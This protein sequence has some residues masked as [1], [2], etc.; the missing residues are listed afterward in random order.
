ML[1]L[2][3]KLSFA[4]RHKHS[5]GALLS[6]QYWL[7]FSACIYCGHASNRATWRGIWEPRGS[8][9]GWPL[10]CQL[11]TFWLFS[12]W[13]LRSPPVCC[14]FMKTTT[15]TGQPSHKHDLSRTWK[16]CIYQFGASCFLKGAFFS[17]QWFGS[18]ELPADLRPHCQDRRLR[19]LTQPLQGMWV[20]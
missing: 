10:T 12:E 1:A 4:E 8:Q 19:P 7:W 5:A 6:E 15:S 20:H 13:L 17:L 11:G 14:T 2:R 16:E 9:M 3:F 18:K